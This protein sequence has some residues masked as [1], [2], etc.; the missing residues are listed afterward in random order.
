MLEE[1]KT[2]LDTLGYATVDGDDIAIKFAVDK[3]QVHVK[4]F[5]NINEI[6][7][8]LN[9][10]MV[11]MAAGDFLYSKKA[12]G[13][14]TVMQIDQIV[15]KIQDGDTTVEYATTTDPEAIF[16]SYLNKLIDGHYDDLIAHRKL[17]W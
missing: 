5:C 17:R 4:H 8:C 16:N 14:L 12:M 7:E 2:R 11:D 6:P 10:V 13:Q 15:K 9:A 3:T 1:V